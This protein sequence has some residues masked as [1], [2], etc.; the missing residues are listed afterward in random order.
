[1]QSD[2]SAKEVVAGLSLR[3]AKLTL[4]CYRKERTGDVER[5]EI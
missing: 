5:K 1:M 4:C 3:E 2:S